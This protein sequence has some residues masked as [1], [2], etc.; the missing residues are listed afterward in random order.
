VIGRD[1]KPGTEGWPLGANPE[2]PAA[3]DQQVLPAAG[4]RGE[5]FGVKQKL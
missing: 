2:N 3:A 5:E 4:F 1:P